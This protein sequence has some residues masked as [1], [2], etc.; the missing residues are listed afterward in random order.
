MPVS[1]T[2]S[3]LGIGCWATYQQ[4]AAGAQGFRPYRKLRYH[5]ADSIYIR[6]RI[7]RNWSHATPWSHEM[8]KL[9]YFAL[10][11]QNREEEGS[12][13]AGFRRENQ[14]WR[15]VAF[16]SLMAQNFPM[17]GFVLKTKSRL[18]WI[19]KCECRWFHEGK[20]PSSEKGSKW[21][22]YPHI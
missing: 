5:W 11:L 13:V 3:L 8:Q 18:F 1:N 9:N 16:I 21:I 2:N 10:S 12:N 4:P 20:L 14:T 19:R 22:D 7:W 15:S 6:M 17:S